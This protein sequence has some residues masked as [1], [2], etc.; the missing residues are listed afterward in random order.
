MKNSTNSGHSGA[1][2]L[3]VWDPLVRLI[4][5]G[6]AL[7]ILLNGA[8]VED[9]GNLHIWIGYTAVG[10]VG[11]RLIWG[12]VGTHYARFSTFPPN[13]SAAL[14]HFKAMIKGNG[15]IH[16]SHNPLGGLMVYNI[17]LTVIALGLTGYMMGTV[18]FFGV[19]W[20]EEI[21]ELFFGW[22][23][24]SIALHIAGVFLDS[25]WTKVP[26]VKSM[27]NGRKQAPQDRQN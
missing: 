2:S 13:P 9:D 21:H 11:T 14:R 1:R 7:C 15:T 19:E 18:Q 27:I 24:I 10:L 22:L 8:V 25:R 4:H 16:L 20:V 17:W 3:I 5:W 26:L 23:L 6:L 12:V